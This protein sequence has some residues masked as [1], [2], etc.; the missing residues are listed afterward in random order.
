MTQTHS[1][2]GELPRPVGKVYLVGAGPGDPGLITLKGLSSLR[3]AD[4]VVYDQLAN[5][6]LLNEVPDAAEKIYVGK[7]AGN[8]SLRQEKINELL[9]QKARHHAVVVRLKGGDPFIFGRGGEEALFLKKSGVPFEVVP[10]VTAGVAALA[11]A[12]IPATMRGLDSSVT[13][14]TGHEDPTKTESQLDWVSLARGKGTLIFY[15]G[16]AQLPNI[17]AQLLAKGKSPKTPVALIQNG[18]QPDQRVIEGTLDSIVPKARDAGVA[19][20]ALIVVGQVV[21]LRRELDW[22]GTRPLKGKRVVVTRA[23]HQ[24]GQLAALLRELGAEAIELPTIR[25]EPPRSW[26][27]V[28]A[29]ISR[30]TRP[31]WVVFTSENGVTQFCERLR[32][33]GLDARW[34]A[35]SRIA[36]IGPGTSRALRRFGLE[37]DLQPEQF[38]AESLAKALLSRGVE[39]KQIAL[40]RAEKTRDFLARTLSE[41]G[42]RVEDFPVYRT[43][44]E[45]NSRAVWERLFS[46]RGILPDWVL[47]TSS[48]TAENFARLFSP[49]ELKKIKDSVKFASIGPITTQSAQKAGLPITVEAEEFTISHLVQR[50]LKYETE[51]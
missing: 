45:E 3:Q 51:L 14:V 49:E 42:A 41:A 17:V 47:F 30:R 4:V 32:T 12:G 10:G 22:F 13:F 7:K 25:I 16:V 2:F 50:I 23:R 36:A 20:P 15:M 31:D 38:V 18:T 26:E 44:P 43:L 39:G 46:E 40:L 37:P 28:D 48:S 9:V 11:Y 33:H 5:P 34:F 24:A 6:V 35:G 8:H 21:S 1:K 27:P 29:L 19:P